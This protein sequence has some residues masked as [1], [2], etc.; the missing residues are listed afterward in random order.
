MHKIEAVSSG[1]FKPEKH[2]YTKVFNA[3]VHPLIS[4]FMN[5]NIDSIIARYCHL[6]P[7]VDKKILRSMITYQPEFVK[8]AGADLFYVTTNKGNRKM[9]IIETNSSPSGQK[10]MPLLDE[11][12][13]YGGYKEL[14]TRVF[15]PAMK[16]K[17]LPKGVL[18]VLYDKNY[19]EVSGYAE[20]L[21]EQMKEIVYIVPCFNKEH[22]SNMKWEEGMLYINIKNTGSKSSKINWKPVRA[23]MR[24]VTQKPWNR[25]PLQTKTM[26][27]NP[28]VVCLAGGRNKMVAAKAYDLLN[29]DLAGTGLQINVP[30]T[31]YDISKNE[32]P[33]W[34]KRFK[35]HAV[36]KVP[37]SNAGQGVFTITNEKELKEFMD[38]PCE[39]E[40]FIVQSL[41]GDY[42]W[43]ST[44]REGKFYHIGTI[45]NKQG[46]IY[47][48]DLR[49]MVGA[50]KDRLIP[51]ALYARRARE[52]LK[53][54]FPKNQT[55]WDMLGT[56]LSIKEGENQW[57]S[58]TSRL[59]IMDRKEFNT[60]GLGIDDL[61]DAYVQTILAVIAIDKM[62]KRLINEQ[63]VFRKKLFKSLNTD[64]QLLN[65]ILEK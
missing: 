57:S 45:P 10:S 52:P 23:A 33:M 56:N 46:E 44:G 29:S 1:N 38:L 35:D 22:N 21:A 20:C 13:E 42:S 8:W 31:I 48:A 9:V 7:N 16:E 34:V 65:E 24:Y 6:H 19:M 53:S 30:E 37:Y 15:I 18:A 55:S 61:I 5:L 63:G 14:I 51:V 3:Q 25:I 27:F 39:Y 64:A 2:Y 40:Q 60:L 43:S 11:H 12:Q 50:G 28:I 62:A 32:I 17:K 58:D 26:I 36:V 41:I 49:M 4:F 54:I 59:I 47:A